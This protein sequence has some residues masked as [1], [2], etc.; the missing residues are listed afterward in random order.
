MTLVRSSHVDDERRVELMPVDPVVPPG[1]AHHARLPESF[2]HP[3]VHVPVD[4]ERRLIPRNHRI[5]V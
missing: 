5:E 1:I 2:V 4:P 3:V